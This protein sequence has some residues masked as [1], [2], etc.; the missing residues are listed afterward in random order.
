MDTASQRRA[1]VVRQ[2]W[3]PVF[4]ELRTTKG[5]TRIQLLYKYDDLLEKDHPHLQESDMLSES[6]LAAIERGERAKVPYYQ[7]DLLCRAAGFSALERA[8]IFIK[9]KLNPIADISD[10][11]PNSN[12]ILIITMVAIHNNPTAMKMLEQLAADR[13]AWELSEKDLFKILATVLN[14][15]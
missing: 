15:I 9:A 14:T 3:G 12:T 8:R 4:K 11:G 1:F 7:L 10:E 6:S 2:K 5:L 13:N